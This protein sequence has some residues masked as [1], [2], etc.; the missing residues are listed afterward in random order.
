VL[1]T[2]ALEFLYSFVDYER[3]EITPRATRDFDLERF[4]RLLHLLDKPQDS[5]RI[6]HIAGT[7]GKGSTAAVLANILSHAGFRVG[8][9]TSPHLK[10]IRERIRVDGVDISRE[11]F[12]EG[13]EQ[14]QM[15]HFL[16]DDSQ[17]GYRTVFEIVT[18]LA[19]LYFQRRNVDWAVVEAGLGGRL[20][21]TNVLTAEITLLTPIDIDHSKILGETL[22]EIAAEKAA[23]IKPG[24]LALSAPQKP[25]VRRVL[26]SKGDELGVSVR[27]LGRDYEYQA[28]RVDLS[29][30]DFLLE[31]KEYHTKLLGG[32][33][34]INC[35]LAGAA[36]L[37]LQEKGLVDG[38]EGAIAPG[39]QNPR[40]PGRL[41]V[42]A[43]KPTLIFDG[44]HNPGG[45]E[46]LARSFKE[47]FGEER[48]V[49]VLG[50]TRGKDAVGIAS[51]LVPLAHAVVITQADFPRAM[52]A[53][54]LARIVGE[55]I[56]NVRVEERMMDAMEVAK[57][58]SCGNR[59][60]L[61]AGSLYLI[62]DVQRKLS[63]DD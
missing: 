46:Q 14:I 56:D 19:L 36:I 18:A 44:A 21:A 13:I 49:L 6:V 17:G 2:D 28:L 9:Y 27:I 43:G 1:Y 26:F 40:W 63:P 48:C 31:G 58:L 62:G 3:Q 57:E 29:G 24:T 23:I 37:Y 50:V 35:A 5:F 25:A 8:L 61:V 12:A 22:S 16:L 47:L 59:P 45:A 10:H 7:N 15:K 51:A 20:D 33:Q 11:E 42:W 54:R 30:T 39:F 38:I 4:A 32:Y 52:P 55:Y 60:I 53:G 34:V 41:E